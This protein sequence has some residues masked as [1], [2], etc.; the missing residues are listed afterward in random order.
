[1]RTPTA[2]CCNMAPAALLW[3][4][5]AHCTQALRLAEI[6]DMVP[7]R[8]RIS[9]T[10]EIPLLDAEDLAP[11]YPGKCQF[12]RSVGDLR[13]KAKVLYMIGDSTMRMQFVELCEAFGNAQIATA[14]VDNVPMR[15][16][17]IS[18]PFNYSLLVLSSASNSDDFTL[19]AWTSHTVM[20]EL[21][22]AG[23]APDAIYFNAGLHYLHLFPCW[24]WNYN[25]WHTWKNIESYT[26]SFL[27]SMSATGSELVLMTS[28]S[29]CE[30]KYNKDCALAVTAIRKDPVKA[31]KPCVDAGNFTLEDCMHGQ[32]VRDGVKRLNGRIK[33]AVKTWQARTHGF[34]IVREV[35]AFQITD[36]KCNFT[37]SGDGR[38]Y[39]PLIYDELLA[40]WQ[41]LG[42]ASQ[43]PQEYV[44]AH[45][46]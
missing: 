31:A 39:R 42:W 2:L 10:S 26:T 15:S 22:L 8:G 3:F 46:C 36:H 37:G 33:G 43:A 14:R 30:E 29:I 18:L 25:S 32:L 17:S 27:D 12:V 20:S 6:P 40:L 34:R 7:T 13:G 23:F 35:D 44:T 4:S 45:G 11:Y 9:W 38:H 21:Q 24:P 41:S 16:C 28:H 5:I 1:M 19:R